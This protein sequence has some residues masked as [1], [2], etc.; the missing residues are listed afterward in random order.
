MLTI[1]L[2]T[3]AV[4]VFALWRLKGSRSFKDA[5]KVVVQGGGGPDPVKPN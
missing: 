3:N 4:L 5:I 1:S 2:I